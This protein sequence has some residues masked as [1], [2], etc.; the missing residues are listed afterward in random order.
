MTD[1][2][3]AISFPSD[4][5]TPRTARN[6][7]RTRLEESGADSGL[8]D[9]LVLVAS[10][11]C[12]NAVEHVDA[13]A[14]TLAI[15]IDDP[16]WWE[17]VLTTHTLDAAPPRT[18]AWALATPDAVSGRGLGIVR[19]LTD[20]VAVESLAGRLVFTCRRRREPVGADIDAARSAP[21]STPESPTSSTMSGRPGGG[22]SEKRRSQ[23][24]DRGAV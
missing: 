17:L 5:S 9:D 2:L 3:H 18:S 14:I 20:H 12:S 23:S 16:D 8:V 21:S 19:R 7:V 10:E 11:L 6:W 15:T 4:V 22:V 24:G 1:D 13:T